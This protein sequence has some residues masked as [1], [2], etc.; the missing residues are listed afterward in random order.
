M[1]QTILNQIFMIFLLIGFGYFLR[2]IKV[3]NDGFTKGATE[4]IIYVT[5]PAMVLASMDRD[6]SKELAS[7]GMKIF[8]L[9]A[10]M[11]T[12]LAL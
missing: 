5:L 10:L 4:L 11:Y 12:V 1:S 7:S 9:G 8:F 6:F 3:M 2:K